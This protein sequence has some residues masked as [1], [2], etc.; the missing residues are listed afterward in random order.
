MPLE[1]LSRIVPGLRRYARALTGSQPDGDALVHATLGAILEDS[2]SIDAGLPLRVGLYRAFHEVWSNAADTGAITADIRRRVDQRL[3]SLD[4]PSRVALLL[5][6]MEGFT[7]QEVAAIVGETEEEVEAQIA[8][9]H[10]DIDRQLATRVLI[11]ED[12][13]IIAL[14]LSNLVRSLGHEVVG[15]AP[16]RDRAIELAATTRPGLVL[17]DIQLA[18][19][20]SGIDAVNSI[21]NGFDVPVIFITAFPERLLTGE[22]PEP[23]YLV[24]KPF[25]SEAVQALIGQALFFHEPREKAA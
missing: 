13:W 7:V 17:A 12:E 6:S 23:T 8:A 1:R 18:D 11:I 5:T 10:R 24:T 4:A 19:G 16:T 9:V 22:R 2:L 3:Q 25:S 14:D 20:S 15:V 21:L